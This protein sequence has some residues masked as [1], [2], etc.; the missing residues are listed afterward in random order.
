MDIMNPR[1]LKLANWI[2][3]AVLVGGAFWWQGREVA[4]GVLVGGLLAVV[5]FHVL[6]HGL[7]GT[8]ERV[9]QNPQDAPGAKAFGWAR[10]FLRFTVLLC[11]IFFLIRYG[12]VNVFGLLV[13]LSTVVLTLI[14][15][16]VV[17]VI[18]LKPKEENPSHGTPHS[19]S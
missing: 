18:K 6:H 11:I 8:L 4:L 12:W 1:H 10:Q 3:L 16:A 5:N 19:V 13:G 14:L 7:R 9:A 17:E 15:A 2:I